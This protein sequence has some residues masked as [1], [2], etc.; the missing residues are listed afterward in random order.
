MI[1]RRCETCQGSGLVQRGGKARKCLQC[2]GFFPFV[3]WQQFFSSDIGNGGPLQQP[4]G[5][6]SVLYKRAPHRL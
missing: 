1:Q 4:R 5:Q 2:G 3:S 6:T